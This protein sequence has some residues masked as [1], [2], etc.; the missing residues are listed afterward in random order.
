MLIWGTLQFS[1]REKREEVHEDLGLL[2]FI[3][4]TISSKKWTEQFEYSNKNVLLSLE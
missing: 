2:I 3:T 1:V 4:L